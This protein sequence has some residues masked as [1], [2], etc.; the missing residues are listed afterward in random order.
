MEIYIEQT[1]SHYK[2]RKINF[3]HPVQSRAIQQANVTPNSHK[4]S[5]SRYKKI[6]H[7]ISSDVI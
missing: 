1:F 7:L 5:V 2:E 4:S 6:D 3:L